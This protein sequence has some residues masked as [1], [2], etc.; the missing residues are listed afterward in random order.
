MVK[1]KGAKNKEPREAGTPYDLKQT[2]EEEAVEAE[3]KRSQTTLLQ[4]FGKKD[5][6]ITPVPQASGSSS[7]ASS[8]AISSQDPVRKLVVVHFPVSGKLPSV[9]VISNRKWGQLQRAS[10]D[11]WSFQ[12]QQIDGEEEEDW[13]RRCIPLREGATWEIT[14]GNSKV[15]MRIA[16]RINSDSKTPMIRATDSSFNRVFPFTTAVSDTPLGLKDAWT[17][18]CK[19]FTGTGVSFVCFDRIELGDFFRSLTAG[20]YNFERAAFYFSQYSPWFCKSASGTPQQ[21]F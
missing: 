9:T 18:K 6:A 5:S 11:L 19:T 14:R 2:A 17:G 16:K 8:V 21:V 7:T 12:P 4:L 3:R 1:T 15:T 10:F 20:F 13:R